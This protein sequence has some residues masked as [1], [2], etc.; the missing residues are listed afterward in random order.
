MKRTKIIFENSYIKKFYKINI[1]Y[2]AKGTG[3]T[4]S[5]NYRKKNFC[6]DFS[7]KFVASVKMS[8]KRVNEWLKIILNEYFGMTL[9]L[10]NVSATKKIKSI[11]NS[12]FVDETFWSEK[13]LRNKKNLYPE[14]FVAIS[15]KSFSRP[16]SIKFLLVNRKFSP[17]FSKKQAEYDQRRVNKMTGGE[18]K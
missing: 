5:W 10:Q 9:F 3:E 4:F 6:C 12:I 1:S 18:P 11:L 13:Q 7:Q 16:L 8:N 2:K 14:S 15:R 17:S